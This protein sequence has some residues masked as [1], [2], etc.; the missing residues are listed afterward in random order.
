MGF[1]YGADLSWEGLLIGIGEVILTNV[2]FVINV[3][4]VKLSKFKIERPP[5]VSR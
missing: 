3:L 1:Y 2:E 5:L 4:I